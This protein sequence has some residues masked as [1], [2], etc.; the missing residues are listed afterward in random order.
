MRHHHLAS[1]AAT[2]AVFVL[3][4][5]MA[6]VP[7]AGQVQSTAVADTGTP[8]RTAWGDPDLQGVY[9]FSTRTPMERPDELAEK[10]FLTEEELAEQD[11]L[12]EQWAQSEERAIPREGSPGTYNAFWTS[13]EKGRLT[14]RTSLIVDPPDG[15]RPALTPEGTEKREARAAAAAARRVDGGA[16]EYVLYDSWTDLPNYSRC[17]SRPMPRVGQSYNHG[18]QIMQTPGYV[19]IHYESMHDA[20]IVPLD[21]SPHIPASMRQLNGDSR[22]HWEGETLVVDWANFRADQEFQ[23]A[24]QQNMHFV[25][26]FTRIDADTIRYEV[27]VEDPTTWSR[28]WTFELLWRADDPN[29]QE[30]EHLYEFACHEGNYKQIENALRGTLAIRESFGMPLSDR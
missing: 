9:T 15:H 18:L 10:E 3:V 14:G 6:A 17:L 23:G 13:N 25:E 2:A 1:I 12:I 24:S 28:P 4:L 21:G 27:T 8:S 5:S 30:P 19:V 16:V 29:Y 11:E 22:G 26:R 20:R 7:L